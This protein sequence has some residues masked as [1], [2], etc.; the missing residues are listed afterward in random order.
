MLY[1]YFTVAI[2]VMN[3][4]LHLINNE[5]V[6]DIFLVYPVLVVIS[7]LQFNFKF[8]LSPF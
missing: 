3:N 8:I 4:I 7:I 2:I 1:N 6:F 5:V